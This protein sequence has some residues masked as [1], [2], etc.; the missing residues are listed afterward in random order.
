MFIAR[1][2]ASGLSAASEAALSSIKQAVAK[3]LKPVQLTKKDRSNMQGNITKFH[4]KGNMPEFWHLQKNSH[5]RVCEPTDPFELVLTT[6]KNNVWI[7]AVNKARKWRTVFQTHAGNVGIK[8]AK[9]KEPEAAYR[10][11]QNA[12]RKLKRLGV[13]IASIKFRRL[14]RVDQCLK[15]FNA[16][17]LNV[18]SLTHEPRLTFGMSHRPR[19]R[20]R[21]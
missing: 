20:R 3:P 13:S 14:M 17:G 15:A 8:K 10:I 9:Q 5:H 21:V 18:K 12:A 4:R 6:S 1:W 2:L 7:T 11:A 19:K 16:E